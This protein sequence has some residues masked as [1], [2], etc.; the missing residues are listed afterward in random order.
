ML[1]VL[2][3]I[4]WRLK[5]QSDSHKTL[6]RAAWPDFVFAFH[7]DESALAWSHASA[8]EPASHQP[9]SDYAAPRSS[10]VAA[11][12]HPRP[13]TDRLAADGC[14]AGLSIVHY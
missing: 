10:C 12:A 8:S 1:A 5:R 11:S 3:A 13:L 9:I 4:G 2:L 14:S 6:E 7:D